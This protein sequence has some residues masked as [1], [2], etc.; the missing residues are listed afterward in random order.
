M[1]AL[2]DI[3][4]EYLQRHAIDPLVL[5]QIGV[6]ERGGRL[7]LPSGRSAALNGAGAKVKQPAGVSLEVWWPTGPPEDGATV[8]VCEGESDA[9]AALSTIGLSEMQHMGGPGDLLAGITVAAVPGTG[10]PA[11]KLAEDLLGVGVAI[12]AYD[13]DEAGREATARAAE[14]LHKAGIACHDLAIPDGRDVADCLAALHPNLRVPWLAGRISD[15]RPI[16]RNLGVIEAVGHVSN[17]IEGGPVAQLPQERGPVGHPPEP[18]SGLFTTRKLDAS[19]FRPV[20]FAWEQRLVAGV[21]NVLAGTE[22]IGKGTMLAWVIAQ[23]TRG[24]LP[25]QLRGKPAR[26]LWVGDE[27]S[28]THVV[29]PRLHAAGADLA[30]VEEMISSDGRLFNVHHDAAELDR[31]IISG[32]FDVVV[33]EALLDHMPAGRNGDPTQHVRESLAP[34]RAV[35]R[36]R[37]TTALATMHTRKGPSS[38]FRDLM[39][40]SHQYNALSRSSLLLAVH[41]DDEDRR[42]IVAGKQNYSRAAITESFELAEHGFELNDHR[43][44]VSLAREFRPEPEITIDSLLASAAPRR[45]DEHREDVLDALSGI[46]RSERSIAKATDL[47]RTTVQRILKDLE[48]E[49][50]AEK[51]DDGWARPIGGSVA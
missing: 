47:P 39:A 4:R 1:T 9:L 29:G 18:R 32:G 13:G 19:E 33:F 10:Y 40:G 21:L 43:F 12:L 27:D 31:I 48:G 2:P 11:S 50:L 25:G 24:G 17:V 46:A 14:E 6:V 8:L 45:R 38:S 37:G 34:T 41:P 35:F 3:G 22:G 51:R 36:R 30:L 28:W 49:G 20:E 5:A 23:L 16:E 15:A 7:I 42:I 26:V 44:S